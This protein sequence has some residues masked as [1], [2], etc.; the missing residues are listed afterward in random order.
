MKP[1][2]QLKRISAGY[3][4]GKHTT[5]IVSDINLTLYSGQIVSLLGANGAGKS[6]LLRT[7]AGTQPPLKGTV[8][9]DG[10]D[11]ASISRKALSQLISV[12]TTDRTMAGGL[13]VA[14]LVGLGRQPHTGF[15]GRLGDNDRAAVADAMHAVG[16]SHKAECFVAELSDGE[17]Q[18]AMIARAVAQATP[19]ILLDEPTSFLDVASRTDVLQLLHR[20]ASESGKAIL[21]SSHDVSLSLALSDRLWLLRNDGHITEGQTED[22]IL[23]GEM[24]HLFS[25]RNVAFDLSTGEFCA[26]M[27]STKKGVS[28]NCS[29]SNLRHWLT[30]A[31]RRNG[32]KV[33][34]NAAIKI[35]ATSPSDILVD[36]NHCD[37][38]EAML[39]ALG[40]TPTK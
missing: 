9:V 34:D 36:S 19:I 6:T 23:A 27:D 18:K 37:S 7:V 15:I 28:L 39:H 1:L 4:V 35:I 31:L 11:L 25:N 16:I 33:T 20:L 32:Y 24:N 17:R 12:V 21:L 13:T 29:D 8:A 40:T 2:L 14:E 30:N 3:V 26:A 10:Q 5:E 22:L 38:I